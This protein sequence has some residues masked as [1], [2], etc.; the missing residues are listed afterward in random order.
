MSSKLHEHPLL[1]KPRRYLTSAA[2]VVVVVGIAGALLATVDA[3]ERSQNLMMARAITA[4][5][6]LPSSEVRTLQAAKNDPENKTYQ[7]IK[8]RLARIRQENPGMQHV[9]LLGRGADGGVFYY[10]D[11]EYTSSRKYSHPGTQYQYA[12]PQL[13]AAFSEDRPFIDAPALNAFGSQASA[14]A[15]VF[16]E[17]T[18]EIVALLG[19]DVRAYDYYQQIAVNALIPLLLAAIPLTVLLRNRRLEAKEHEVLQLKTQFVSV[20]SHELRSPLT[21]ALWGAQSLLKDD[22]NLNDKQKDTLTAIYNSTATSLASVNEILDFSI[23]DRGKANKLQRVDVN[24]VTILNEVQKTLE[25]SAEESGVK[26]QLTGKWPEHV[27]TTGDV[28]AL[29]RAFSNIL[30]NAIKYS[31]Q[32]ST[33]DLSH[34]H[35][36]SR[37][38]IAVRDHGI[39]IPEEEQARVMEGYYRASNASLKL[40]HGTG[41]GLWVTRMLLEQHHGKLWLESKV[42]HGTTVFVMLPDK[43]Q[44]K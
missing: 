25:L 6:A 41:M 33:V 31:H 2:L 7:S 10:V 38:V 4:A 24:L 1:A 29:K 3:M 23:F 34:K 8:R 36:A 14:Y 26:V 9:Y 11:S 27:M 13:Q 16:D 21:G 18:G 28:G 5:A 40:T 30:S 15:P 35:D 17:A 44:P 22:S 39:G 20:A 42:G 12:T 19:L 32:G 43:K 37:H